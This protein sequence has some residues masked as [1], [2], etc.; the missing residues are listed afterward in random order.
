VK[1]QLLILLVCTSVLGPVLVAPLDSW[2]DTAP[3]KAIID[4]VERV[5]KEGSP[6][7]VP[8]AERIAVFDN[9]GTLWAEQPAYFQA[10]FTFDRV[11]A[12]RRSIPNGKPRNRLLRC[13][14]ET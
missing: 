4:F 13:L 14:R 9:D 8:M 11:K 5:T 10:L 7:F 2:N 1:H 3:K 6:D 12:L